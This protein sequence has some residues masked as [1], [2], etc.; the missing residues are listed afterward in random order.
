MSLPLAQHRVREVEPGELD[1]LRVID[2]EA[3]EV[4]VVKRAVDLETP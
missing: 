2:A 1:L 3:L 4:P